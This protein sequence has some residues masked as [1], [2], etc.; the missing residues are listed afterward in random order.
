MPAHKATMLAVGV[1][2]FPL[3]AGA[4]M[5]WCLGGTRPWRALLRGFLATLAVMLLAW[6]I[7]GAPGLA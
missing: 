5:A 7:N 3:V 2:I 1:L 6:L 4:A